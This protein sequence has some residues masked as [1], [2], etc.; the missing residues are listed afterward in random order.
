MIVL[1]F[2]RGGDLGSALIEW[3]GHGQWSHVDAV[4][5]EDTLLGARTDGGVAIRPASYLPSSIPTWRFAVPAGDAATNEFCELLRGQIGK[6]YDWRAI[7]GFGAGRDWRDPGAWF[8]SELQA[9][10]LERVGRLP[11]LAT[12]CNK[13]TPDDLALVLGAVYPGGVDQP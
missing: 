12:P 10:A 1:Q 9:W 2:C 11:L 7:A 8:C 5:P 13:L 3:Y 4:M 6:P